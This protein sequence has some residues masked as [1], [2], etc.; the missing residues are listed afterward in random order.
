MC[1][2]LQLIRN[3]APKVKKNLWGQIDP[4]T[5]RPEIRNVQAW[6]FN[7][8]LS[9]QNIFSVRLRNMYSF[10][11]ANAQFSPGFTVISTEKT[12]SLIRCAALCFLYQVIAENYS[13]Y[14]IYTI[15]YCRY[16]LYWPVPTVSCP[17]SAAHCLLPNVHCL[18]PNV[19][20]S[21]FIGCLSAAL[22]ESVS[23]ERDSK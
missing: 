11:I 13:M 9:L 21:L 2:V 23:T 16:T 8:D 1:Y 20:R 18:L 10:L 4:E 14:Y 3:G 15:R 12:E 5:K 6:H 22:T 17:M 19:H 7:I